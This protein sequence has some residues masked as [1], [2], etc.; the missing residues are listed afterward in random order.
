MEPETDHSPQRYRKD[1]RQIEGLGHFGHRPRSIEVSEDFGVRYQRT[2]NGVEG[3]TVD[4]GD[5][6]IIFENMPT[7]VAS[8]IML[9]LLSLRGQLR[10]APA[11][12]DPLGD[13]QI[14][15]RALDFAEKNEIAF[16]SQLGETSTEILASYAEHLWGNF[17]VEEHLAMM[18]LTEIQP[19]LYHIRQ[20]TAL[21]L[22]VTFIRFQEHYESPGLKGQY[23]SLADYKSWY[24]ENGGTGDFS[25]YDAW[26]GFNVPDHVFDSFKNG[27]FDP[28]ATYEDA[29]LT[30]VQDL[31]RP[32]YIIGTA[33]RFDADYMRHET[34]H[35]LYYLSD[36]YRQEVQAV[37]ET[38]DR[39]PIYS[40]LERLGYD[41]KVFDDEVHAYLL[42]GPETLEEEGVKGTPY[43]ESSR[44]LRA[45]FKRHLHSED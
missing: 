25:Y 2:R 30:L 15:R 4:C 45:I 38:V 41:S 19:G 21:S 6:Q 5:A 43:K 16:H 8:G 24:R 10:E 9:E 20:P 33:G 39:R 13:V 32:F 29:L 42:D 34:G 27:R 31:P 36:D 28:I 12:D 17:S 44:E 18:R 11:G 23:F 14:L 7:R 22:A 37:I 1:P 3:L 35:G 40:M 26:A